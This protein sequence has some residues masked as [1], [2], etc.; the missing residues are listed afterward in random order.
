[1]A[2]ASTSPYLPPEGWSQRKQ[3]REVKRGRDEHGRPW[4]W[5]IENKTGDPTG[6]I[7]PLFTA[8][9][10]PEQH[11]LRIDPDNPNRILID[12]DR[13]IADIRLTRKEWDKAGRQRS[14]KLY[15][16]KYNPKEDFTEEVLDI[17]G[18]PPQAW[19]PVLAAKQGNPWMLGKTT[20]VDIRLAKF[21]EPEDLDKDEEGNRREPDYSQLVDRPSKLTEENL[22]EAR[23]DDPDYRPP[24]GRGGARNWDE[25]MS[26]TRQQ[27]VTG[28]P[29]PRAAGKGSGG[30][31]NKPEGEKLPARQRYPKG[32]PKSGQFIPK[33][34]LEPATAGAASE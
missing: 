30:G 21:F 16:Q 5:T 32:H 9:Y 10:I 18:P 4:H 1:M 7:Q 27:V 19:E 17:I 14:Q 22:L 12:Y 23:T 2:Q 33:S 28:R 15:G 13:A 31:K 24:V 11:Y 29:Q 20:R 6:L 3:R 34:E 26:I 8:P 25:D